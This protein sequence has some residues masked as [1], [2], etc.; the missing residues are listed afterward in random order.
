V[1]CTAAEAEPQDFATAVEGFGLSALRGSAAYAK[2]HCAMRDLRVLLA[3]EALSLAA[4]AFLH[5]PQ[6][7]AE[8]TNSPSIYEGT[9][10]VVLL[11][12]LLVAVARPDWAAWAALITQAFAIV[13]AWIGLFLAI[14]GVGP[15]SVPD[16]VFHV[17]IVVLLAWGLQVAWQSRST[18][19]H[20]GSAAVS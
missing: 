15:N 18:P 2:E 9:I 6:A 14:R 1:A 10:A 20:R 7:G 3:I 17:A 12:G 16:L 11:V 4:A 19:S 13:G 8:A 5:L